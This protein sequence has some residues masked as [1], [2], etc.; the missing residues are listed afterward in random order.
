[1][2]SIPLF[3]DPKHFSISLSSFSHLFRF[4]FFFF[5]S[6]R[7]HTRCLSDWSSDVC[8]S[9]LPDHRFRVE[10]AQILTERDIPRFRRLG[11]LPSMQAT[12]C[13]SDMEWAVERLGPD[14]DRKSVV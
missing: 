11:A 2:C 9:D 12:H 7:R 4:F 3:P 14:R 5:S 13:T 6:R 10:H 1:M 8:S